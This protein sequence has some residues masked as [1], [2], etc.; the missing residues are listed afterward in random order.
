[1]KQFIFLLLFLFA[2][3]SASATT[4]Y[5]Q[6]GGSSTNCTT[7][8]TQGTPA[9][10][11]ADAMNCAISAGGTGN[12][13]EIRDSSSAVYA[14][15]ISVWPSATAGSH[16]TLKATN[17]NVVIMRPPSG[18]H[19]L[20]I[21]SNVTVGPNINVDGVNLVNDE[22]GW[23]VD[24]HS[25]SSVTFTDNTIVNCHSHGIYMG[26][27]P[28]TIIRNNTIHHAGSVTGT[29]G[30]PD[31][32]HGV[33]C[34]AGGFLIEGNT[35]YDIQGYGIHCYSSVTDASNN[36]VRNNRVHDW[37]E[38]SRG[39]AGILVQN[40]NGQVYNN[41]VYNG[42]G[43]GI[44]CYGATTNCQVY[45]NTIYNV[46]DGGGAIDI[47]SGSTGAL[48]R[49][50]LTNTVVN[51]PA[52]N[53]SMTQSGNVTTG[54]TASH[55]VNAA[56][57]DFHLVVGSSAIGAGVVLPG[58]PS[59]T[60]WC[61][62]FASISRPQAATWDAGAYEFS[63]GAAVVVQINSTNSGSCNATLTAGNAACT[64]TGQANNTITLSG[65]SSQTTGTVTWSCDRC[66]GTNATTG[67][68][69]VW[70]TS[71]ITLKSG[72]N[73]VT[74]T[75]TDGAS[76]G[77]DSIAINYAPTYPGDALVLALGFEDGAGTTATDSSGNTNT[78]TL[79]NSPTWVTT[80][81]FG[82]ALL[83]NGINQYV[84]VTDTNSLRL[85]QSFT[86]S[87]WVQPSAS[88]ATFKAVIYKDGGSN[89]APY[90][91]YGVIASFGCT[92]GGYTGIVTVNGASGPQYS[93][94]S[95][96]PLQTGVWTH[97]AV[98]YD[99][100][101]AQ[102][103]LYRM[104]VLVS[105]VSASGYMEPST[106]TTPLDLRIGGSEFGEN[107]QGLI[108][109]V[110]VYTKALPITAASNTVAGAACTSVNFTDNS[111]VATASIVG[112]MNCPI[113]NLNPPSQFKLSAGATQLK[114]GASATAAKVGANP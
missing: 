45:S 29:S 34:D 20:E 61:I 49:N 84:R 14:E 73:N 110:R 4:W 97:I 86:L 98:T 81:R 87:A 30:F 59:S 66:T 2:A 41:L 55:F 47:G 37:G 105:T 107:W 111:A 72:I 43:D 6:K 75:G 22:S 106:V 18:T 71:T 74:I 8:Q 109:E 99:N 101:T 79:V 68:P 21:S 108:D 51:M 100:A 7:I 42:H 38:E 39:G 9:G 114:L 62:D 89:G 85:T 78:G 93:A 76:S 56:S 113:I 19:V 69:S 40:N 83:L 48:V 58:C 53:G 82:K 64:I 102:L 57:E 63:S 60:G 50:N 13:V 46:H 27:A 3:T 23:C 103:K 54:T 92:A 88:L 77:T 91:L 52:L 36:I 90:S 12:T 95:S 28:G 94:C 33:Y 44:V 5:V 25:V 16:F 112:N 26:T 104:G 65:V 32:T 15:S 67:T 80:G 24:I 17:P 10:T 1:M 35:I 11:I 31:Q 70:T 96:L